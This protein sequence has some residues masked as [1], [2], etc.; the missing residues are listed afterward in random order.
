VEEQLQSPTKY[1]VFHPATAMDT[2]AAT[3]DLNGK[4]VYYGQTNLNR[5]MVYIPASTKLEAKQFEQEVNKHQE[6]LQPFCP[7][8]PRVIQVG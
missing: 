4:T 5:W 8:K 1:A 7:G 2:V 3:I 6:E